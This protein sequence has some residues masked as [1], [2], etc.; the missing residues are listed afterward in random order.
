MSDSETI[1]YRLFN[2][3]ENDDNKKVL[4]LMTEAKILFINKEI[5]AQNYNTLTDIYS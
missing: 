3:F 2:S 4:D 5:T 1:E